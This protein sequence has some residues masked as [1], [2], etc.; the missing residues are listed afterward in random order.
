MNKII[1]LIIVAIALIPLYL[2]I[3]GVYISFVAHP[4]TGVLVLIAE[5]APIV[6]GIADKF[7]NYNIP[8]VFTSKFITN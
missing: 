8:E 4:I 2:W 5:P 7:W 3:H 1:I 6:V